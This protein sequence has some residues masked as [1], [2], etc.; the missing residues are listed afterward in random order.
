MTRPQP[1]PGLDLRE[2]ENGQL[3]RFRG[4]LSS[5]RRDSQ[6]RAIP[7]IEGV[8]FDSFELRGAF[9]DSHVVALFRSAEYPGVQFG[10][11]RQLYDELG[12][13]IRHRYADVYL[14]E[15]I[16]SGGLPELDQCIPDATGVVWL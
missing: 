12:N 6:G 7:L 13:P 1:P 14:A 15:D 2:F 3:D 9:P 10:R 11:K 4:E 5:P 8:T 16:L